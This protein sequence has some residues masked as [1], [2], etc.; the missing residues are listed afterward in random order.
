MGDAV[1]AH[2]RA[3]GLVA[4][5]HGAALNL[6]F[7]SG[8]FRTDAAA[9]EGAS[10]TSGGGTAPG[11]LRVLLEQRQQSLKVAHRLFVAHQ[12]A[13]A[14]RARA[15]SPSR[16]VSERT[17]TANQ[18]CGVMK[19]LFPGL[20]GGVCVAADGKEMYDAGAHPTSPPRFSAAS[21]AW[22]ESPATSGETRPSRLGVESSTRAATPDDGATRIASVQQIALEQLRT[23]HL[24]QLQQLQSLQ[25]LRSLQSMS[26]PGGA[27]MGALPGVVASLGGSSERLAL[28]E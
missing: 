15:K 27:A 12:S 20:D 3:A 8:E 26:G 11:E 1:N 18:E 28:G 10:E 14:L 21:L 5:T 16:A 9:P 23:R 19:A 22:R 24:Q 7:I 13:T 4:E 25:S 17:R 2:A 6:P